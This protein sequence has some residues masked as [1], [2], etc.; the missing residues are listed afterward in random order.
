MRH[1]SSLRQSPPH[2]SDGSLGSRGAFGTGMLGWLGRACAALVVLL[3]MAWSFRP[4]AH[5]DLFWQLRTGEYV[6]TEHRVPLTDPFSYTRLGARWIS[7]EWGFGALVWLV[8]RASGLVGLLGLT[9]LLTLLVG[10]LVARRAV[11]RS[12]PTEWTLLAP[13]LALALLSCERMLF[14]RAAL[15]AAVL[16]AV[17]LL[18]LERWRES[19]KPRYL[20]A[21]VATLWVWANVHSNVLIGLGIVALW[22]IEALIA[23]HWPRLTALAEVSAPPARAPRA[24]AITFAAGAV[25]S[26]CNPNGLS[27]LEYPF[28]LQRLLFASGI[29]WDLGEFATA[30]PWSNAPL[31]LMVA[32]LLWGAVTGALRRLRPWEWVALPAFFLLTVRGSRFALELTIVTIPALYR[33][34]H[35]ERARLRGTRVQAAGAAVIG[36]LLLAKLVAAMPERPLRL[37]ARSL[38]TGASKF[39]RENAISGQLFHNSNQGGYLS[40]SLRQPIFWDGRNDVFASLTKEVTTIPFP[41][42]A[43]HYG[44]DVLVLTERE[45]HDLQPEAEG[46]RWGLMYWDDGTAVYLRRIPRFADLLARLELHA[47]P[48]FSDGRTLGTIAKDGAAAKAARAELGRLLTVEPEN[49]RALYFLGVLELAAG[50]YTNARSHLESA[51]RLGD[52]ELLRRALA[53]ARQIP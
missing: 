37:Y 41:E 9:A 21:S 46:P 2:G 13:L 20:L 3:A 4:L 28:L 30:S 14:L 26:L 18:L 53:V 24:L 23:A 52:N 36:L 32:L 49:Q 22:A 16:L 50:E 19:G 15:L 8:E 25:L 12:E 42:L 51:Q 5:D 7:H 33:V 44:V 6:A 31:L 1:A 47:F 48:A 17:L 40:W 38:P 34:L 11:P 29:E 27:A 45:F 10:V 43:E 35:D 39:L